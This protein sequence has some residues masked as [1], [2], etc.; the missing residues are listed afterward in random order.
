MQTMIDDM[1]KRV[2][3]RLRKEHE[4]VHREGN[5]IY[6]DDQETDSGGYKNERNNRITLNDDGSVEI[7]SLNTILVDEKNPIAA[8]ARLAFMRSE[9][10]NREEARKCDVGIEEH[11]DE[12]K[13]IKIGCASGKTLPSDPTKLVK[14]RVDE[15]I[16]T[17]AFVDKESNDLLDDF[18][19][20]TIS[21]MTKDDRYTYAAEKMAGSSEEWFEESPCD[22]INDIAEPKDWE[23][24][25]T[26]GE[27]EAKREADCVEPA[28]SSPKKKRRY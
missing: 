25:F 17:H 8:N 7:S 11:D 12:W 3:S 1:A 2:P 13:A 18:H 27:I 10:S 28:V 24:F 22:D 15:I 14:D 21:Q 23:P 16:S 20:L 9:N 19:N 5:D 4:S 6:V 26:A